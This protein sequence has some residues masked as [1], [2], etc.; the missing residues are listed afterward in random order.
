MTVQMFMPAAGP[1][2]FSH[3]FRIAEIITQLSDPWN[4][5]G[6][7]CRGFAK[8]D[9]PGLS[10]EKWSQA[11]N[12]YGGLNYPKQYLLY[13]TAMVYYNIAPQS[14]H[15][16]CI[17]PK[18]VPSCL[19]ILQIYTAC[20]ALLTRISDFWISWR[21]LLANILSMSFNIRRE[22]TNYHG[23]FSQSSPCMFPS[24]LYHA[25]NNF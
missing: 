19:S 5:V 3:L 21:I 14:I 23:L 17:P 7:H 10:V 9:S 25:C 11:R 15:I 22:R 16:S 12:W 8:R 2:F 1:I 24:W 18:L 13:T 20:T 6:G 4:S